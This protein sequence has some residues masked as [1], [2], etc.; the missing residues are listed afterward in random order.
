[1]KTSPEV[2]I[3]G[4]GIIGISCAYHLAVKHGIRRVWL[5]DERAPLSLTSDKSSECYRNWWPDPV[6]VWLMNRS[7]DQMEELAIQSGNAFHLNR[8]GYLYVTADETRAEAWLKLARSISEYGGGS[9]RIHRGTST[10]LP[11]HSSPEAGFDRE[12]NGADLMLDPALINNHYPYLTREVVAALHARRAG[13]FSAQQLGML[14]LEQARMH[15]VE[16][17][18]AR[19]T[20]ITTR[21]GRVRSVEL[22]HSQSID[23]SIFVNAAGPLIADVNRFLE[24]PPLPIANELH[25]KAMINDSLEIIPR[26]APLLIW[27]DPQV[28]AWKEEERAFIA[29][30]DDITWMLDELP[31]GSHARPEG[32]GGSQ[33]LLI[34]WEYCPRVTDPV[35]PLPYD[36]Q[37]PEMAIRG[38]IRM[39]PGLLDYLEKLP[40]AVIDGGYYTRTPEN[41]PL[42]GPL[43]VEGAFICGA[44]SGHGI[45]AA[46]S[47][48]EILAAH[49]MQAPLAVEAMAFSPARYNDPAYL[50]KVKNWGDTGQ[51]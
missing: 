7:I 9:P 24:I 30:D 48:G 35:W 42:I 8:R 15:G 51:L 27:S 41:R 6:M 46:C 16:L 29:A 2:L 3:C 43:P 25:L 45:M 1:M 32:G 49:L 5:V 34:L 17:V 18:Q 31:A 38:L 40:R 26:D 13:W 23:T 12:L 39:L 21:G 50:K 10:Q 36:P 28:L 19:V 33:T 20:G 22:N 37:F 14:L 4:A 44:F 47:A 11:Y